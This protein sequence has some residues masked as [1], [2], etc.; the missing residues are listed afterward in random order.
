MSEVS[1]TVQATREQIFAVLSDGWLFASWV[2]GAAHIRQ[3]DPGWPAVGTKIHHSVGPWPLQVRDTTEVRAVEPPR[4]LELDAKAWP[5]GAAI[6]RLELDET[7]PGTTRITMYERLVR[8]PLGLI[9]HPVQA[10]LLHPRN[11][12]SLHRLADIVSGRTAAPTPSPA[13]TGPR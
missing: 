5:F 2:V 10:A 4:R 12:E 6:V 9:P 3:V 1:V 8:G 7:A 11:R 13:D